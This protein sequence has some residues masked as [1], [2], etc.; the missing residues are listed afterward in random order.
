V[1]SL[2]PLDA[3]LNLPPEEFSHG[4]RRRVA[5]ASAKESFDEVAADIA[6]TT[7]AEVARRQVEELAGRA[8]VDFDDF[9]AERERRA[10]EVEETSSL[11]VIST[12]G[13]GIVMRQEDLRPATQAKA[14]S[15][16]HKL[17]KRLSPGGEAQRQAH[18]HGGRGL[19]DRPLPAD[20]RRHRLR[21]PGD[22]RGQGG[23][24]EPPA[25]RAQARLVQRR[26]RTRGGDR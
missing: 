16:S 21:A 4:V 23:A 25:S 22:G 9:Y 13:K 7:A 26:E 2:F 19:H 18:E 14:A 1:E 3:E 5:M 8:A 15:R 17:E 24:E 20:G 6:E 12:D 11:L 10:E